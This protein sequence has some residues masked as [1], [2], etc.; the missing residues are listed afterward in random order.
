MFR[1]SF[2]FAIIASTLFGDFAQGKQDQM[3][4][5]E[6]M[7]R[8]RQVVRPNAG[9]VSVQ[10]MTGFGREWSGGSQLFWGPEKRGDRLDLPFSIA[11]SGNYKITSYFTQGPDYG[12]VRIELNGNSLFTFDGFSKQVQRSEPLSFDS[13]PLTAGRN[14]LSLIVAGKGRESS[15]LLVGFDQMTIS[16]EFN[17][18]R[19]GAAVQGRQAADVAKFAKAIKAKSAIKDDF[20]AKLPAQLVT[21]LPYKTPPMKLLSGPN[22]PA[23]KV[24]LRKYILDNHMA[25]RSQ[26]NRGTCSVFAT[27]FCIEYGMTKSFGSGFADMSEEFLNAV[28]NMASGKTDDGDFFY[29]LNKGYQNFGLCAEIFMKYQPTMAPPPNYNQLHLADVWQRLQPDFVKSWDN[30]KGL[31]NAQLNK[32]IS[33]LDQELPVAAGMYWPKKGFFKVKSIMGVDLMDD[34]GKPNVTDGHSIV[35]VG[36]A[37]SQLFPGGGFF[38]FRNSWGTDF[39]ENGYGYMS[40]EYVQKY[41]N[42]LLVYKLAQE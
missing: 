32:A 13:V 18:T 8:G 6:S 7:L 3:I 15:G 11:S 24:D 4:E 17:T 34:P 23:L 31:T 20:I 28:G 41:T 1:I 2:A 10:D 22:T 14:T 37:K 16:P 35:L 29:V 40:F 9:N 42:D 19:V 38:V 25:I 33:Y 39:G 30:T 26:G 12:I 5:G 36:Y 27:T 21:V